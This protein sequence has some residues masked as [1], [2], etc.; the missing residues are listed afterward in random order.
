VRLIV[1]VGVEKRVTEEISD[2]VAVVNSPSSSGP[3]MMQ[4]P[5]DTFTELDAIDGL[6]GCAAIL[7]AGGGVYGA[8]GCVWIG[9]EGEDDQLAACES[10][11]KE[12]AEE[13]PC[14]V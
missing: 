8:E 6:T 11:M 2:L 5:G 12:L 13:P 9:V 14:K 3:R 7:L 1:P 10:L 4:L